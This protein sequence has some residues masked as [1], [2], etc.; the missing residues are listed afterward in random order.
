MCLSSARQSVLHV[1][2]I[3]DFCCPGVRMPIVAPSELE[4]EPMQARENQPRRLHGPEASQSSGR[5][6]RSQQRKSVAQSAPRNQV[7]AISQGSDILLPLLPS[8]LSRLTCSPSLS[9]LF[10]FLFVRVW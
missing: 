2:G 4:K 8:Q 1:L 10:F 5:D 7:A 3:P 6:S 9:R